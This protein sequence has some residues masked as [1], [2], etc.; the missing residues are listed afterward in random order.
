[1]NQIRF[2]ALDR[3]AVGDQHRQS[4]GLRLDAGD[5]KPLEQRRKQKHIHRLKQLRY[6]AAGS[7]KFHPRGQPQ[8]LCLLVDFLSALTGVISHQQQN[9]FGIF[10]SGQPEKYQ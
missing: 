1:M 2:P 9:R 6:V 3:D 4:G 10:R 8:L 7:Q 5:G